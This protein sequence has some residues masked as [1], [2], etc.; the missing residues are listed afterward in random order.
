MLKKY[1]K[2]RPSNFITTS[3]LRPP[4]SYDQRPL[5]SGH[6]KTLKSV[7]NDNFWPFLVKIQIHSK[8][9]IQNF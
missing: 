7:Q 9:F 8:S 4:I 2:S 5:L 3:E 1:N 6:K